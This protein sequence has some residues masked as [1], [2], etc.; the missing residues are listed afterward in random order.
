MKSVANIIKDMNISLK[1]SSDMG[2]REE[3]KNDIPERSMV[4]VRAKRT[5]KLR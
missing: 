3:K 2:S 5:T 4:K 1:K